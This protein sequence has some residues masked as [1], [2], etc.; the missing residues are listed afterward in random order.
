MGALT[1][2]KKFLMRERVL[3]AIFLAGLIILYSAVAIFNLGDDT[4]PQTFYKLR[5]EEVIAIKFKKKVHEPKLIFYTGITQNDFELAQ[6]WNENECTSNYLTHSD[7]K[8]FA[9]DGPFRWRKVEI[10]HSAGA[11]FIKNI[12]QRTI[13]LGEVAVAERNTKIPIE[14]YTYYQGF[15]GQEKIAN[16]TDEQSAV[17]LKPSATNSSYFDEVYF[18]QTAYQFATGQVGYETTHPP[19]GKIIQA[20]P[21]K[22]L[23]RM[24]PFTWRIAGVLAGMLIIVAVYGLA[25]ELFK[26]SA[27]AR[28]AAIL[29]A[30]SGLHFTQTRL[31]TVDSYLCLFTIL[32]FLFMLKY[33]NSDKLRFMIGAGICFGAACSVKWSGAFAGI[34]LLGLWL[35]HFYQK[36][37]L[38]IDWKIKIKR[39]LLLCLISGCC[40]IIIPAVIYFSS[41]LGFSKTTLATIPSDVINQGTNLYEFHASAFEP[42]PYGSKWYTWPMAAQPILYSIYDGSKI[43]LM[44]NTILIYSSILALLITAFFAIRKRDKKSLFILLGYCSLWLPYAWIERTMFL[45]HYLPAS[46]F[47]LLAIVNVFYQI[48]KTRKIIWLFLLVS[49]VS[50]IVAYPSMSGL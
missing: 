17:K 5:P 26:S 32:A 24:T 3:D 39:A 45:Y 1:K 41:Y 11:I 30:L 15:L 8:D 4:A 10:E 29:V 31:G 25:K 27:Y 13:E 50:F 21:I 44:G 48:P 47:A 16:L 14:V 18:A 20:I 33:I 35:Y 42:H 23:G 9:V 12:S 37:K 19:L 36:I 38:K 40:F 6:A 49:T 2:L 34:G 7:F 22:L 46:I 43:M 28:V